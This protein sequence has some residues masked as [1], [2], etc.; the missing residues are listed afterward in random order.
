[1]LE[2]TLHRE[3]RLHKYIESLWDSENRQLR[4]NIPWCNVVALKL[5]IHKL[6]YK[7]R[8]ANEAGFIL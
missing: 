5:T 8:M 4:S 6:R 3:N 1:M 2:L 7:S